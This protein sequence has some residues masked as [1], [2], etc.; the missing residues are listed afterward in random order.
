M[1][2]ASAEKY[3]FLYDK[4]NM[5][6]LMMSSIAC[7]R[8]KTVRAGDMLYIA[9]FPVWSTR[10]Q[11]E[12]AKNA[13]KNAEA[14]KWVNRR[15]RRTK[16][17]QIVHANFGRDDYFVTTTYTETPSGNRRLTEEDYLD[18]PKD[19]VEA[20]SNMRKFIRAL[21]TY[22]KKLGGAV[23]KLKYLYVT[24]ETYTKHPDPAYDRARYHHHML[25]GRHVG[26]DANGL[27]VILSRDAIEE[28]WQS[29]PF[30]SGRVRCDRLQPDK[31]NGLS[32]VA[33]YMTK[34]DKGDMLK[35]EETARK[36]QH[37]YAGSKNLKRPEPTVADHKISRRR[38]QRLAQDVRACGSEI[39]EKLY[40]G[41]MLADEPVVRT[42]EYVEGAYIYA[43]MIKREGGSDEKKRAG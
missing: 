5:Q 4:E 32:G 6:E 34:S 7:Q 19:E 22:V 36:K 30:A 27:D 39:F 31:H 16:F 41:Y 21:R 23:K 33:Q 8:T 2:T 38:V 15:N 29:M 10:A 42:S 11:L 3:A 28:I 26:K 1:Y 40:P 25:I 24:E 9:S 20:Q 14:V 43:K 12:Q 18:E 35:T 13:P 17:E 37:R